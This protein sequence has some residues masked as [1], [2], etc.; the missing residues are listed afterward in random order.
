[1]PQ[2]I[3]TGYV[4][5]KGSNLNLRSNPSLSAPIIGKIPNGSE[6]LIYNRLPDWDLVGYA[7]KVGYVKNNYVSA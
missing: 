7:G 2:P 6:I 4:V 1:M 3:S 5:T